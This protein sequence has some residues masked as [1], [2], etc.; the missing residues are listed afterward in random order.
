MGKIAKGARQPGWVAAM[1]PFRSYVDICGG[2]RVVLCITLMVHIAAFPMD[3]GHSA[4]GIGDM[5]E[6]DLGETPAVLSAKSDW[7]AAE[8]MSAPNEH[9]YKPNFK[10]K[11]GDDM[12]FVERITTSVKT[13]EKEKMIKAAQKVWSSAWSLT[14]KP[15]PPV[16]NLQKALKKASAATELVKAQKKSYS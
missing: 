8:R 10:V 4:Q 7:E 9:R 5:Q 11:N 2:P 3:G 1:A 13:A 12:T 6:D 14:N 15:E 16:K